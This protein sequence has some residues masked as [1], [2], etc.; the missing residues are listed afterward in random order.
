MTG[1]GE[2]D[3]HLF[4]VSS[5]VSRR[6]FLLCS[7]FVFSFL[8]FSFFSLPQLAISDLQL[9]LSAM[10]PWSHFWIWYGHRALWVRELIVHE[11]VA[12]VSSF[13]FFF[14]FVLGDT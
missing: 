7:F 11:L 9:F 1:T 3:L 10:L 6:S 8:F 13:F 14:S 5:S 4:F 12:L 2:Q